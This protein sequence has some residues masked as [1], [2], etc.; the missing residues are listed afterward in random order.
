[1]PD[2]SKCAFCAAKPTHIAV[3]GDCVMLVCDAHVP[4]EGG[5]VYPLSAANERSPHYNY[6]AKLALRAFAY[7]NYADYLEECKRRYPGGSLSK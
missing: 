1:M 6:K 7:Q 3:E 2:Y 4:S 5:A